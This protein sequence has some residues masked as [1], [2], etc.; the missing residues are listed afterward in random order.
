MIGFDEVFED[1]RVM[2]ILRGLGLE[3][4]LELACRAWDA[5]LRAV[6]VPIQTPRDLDALRATAEAAAER[7]LRVGAGTVLT[8]EQLGA[9]RRAGAAFVVSP[10]FDAGLAAASE[11]AGMAALVGVGSATDIQQA[12]TRG[13][14]WVKVFPA[15]PLG[16]GWLRAMRAPFPEVRMVAT[17]GV[18]SGNAA[19]FL[20]AGAAAVAVGAA[21][22]DPAEL[23]RLARI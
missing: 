13:H 21:A 19:A 1:T 6:E 14:R 23:R 12:V 7:G 20:G 8:V 5:G 10:G 22:G 17:G 9:A 4:T 15:A 16:P 18:D 2:V 11:R 3:R